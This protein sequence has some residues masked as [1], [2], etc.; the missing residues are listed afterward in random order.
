MKKTLLALGAL[1][2]GVSLAYA[3]SHGGGVTF[4][5]DIRPLMEQHCFACH[6][7]HA[8]LL[9]AFDA[10]KEK[11][12]ALSQGPR[13]TTLEMVKEFVSG[14]DAGA[15]MRRL[16]DGTNTQDGSPGNMFMYLGATDEERQENLAVFKQWVGHWTLKRS[17]E[18]TEEDLAQFKMHE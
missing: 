3:A 7:E 14:D 11:Y 18:L 8:P 4:Q 16:D 2:F 13:M 10:D 15:L 1:C 9:E 6:G 12:E 17:H 5:N